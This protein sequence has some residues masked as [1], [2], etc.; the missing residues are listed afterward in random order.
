[1][2]LICI[3]FA[4][5]FDNSIG[6]FVFLCKQDLA[7]NMIV[8]NVGKGMCVV[9]CKLCM[10]RFLLLADRVAGEWLPCGTSPIVVLID[11]GWFGTYIAVG[12]LSGCARFL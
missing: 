1:M 5:S 11:Q 3:A 2:L 9:G 7:I 8:S 6:S 12:I 4:G 10:H